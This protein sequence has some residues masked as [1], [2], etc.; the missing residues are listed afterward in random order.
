MA[1]R[2]GGRPAVNEIIIL[3][4]NMSEQTTTADL[5]RISD[6]DLGLWVDPAANLDEGALRRAREA[7]CPELAAP[8]QRLH[9]RLDA[10]GL[11]LV[12]PGVGGGIRVRGDFLGGRQGWRL[13]QAR[14]RREALARACDL[15]RLRAPEVIDATAGLGRDTALLAVLGARVTAIERQPAIAALLRDAL[16]RASADP[17]LGGSFRAV[18][19]CRAD[20]VDWLGRQPPGC[21]DVIYLDPMFQ[22]TGTAAVTK[23]MQ[24]LRRLLVDEPA[25]PALLAAARARARRRVVVKR[26]RHAPA[27]AGQAPDFSL[28]GRSTRFDVYVTSREQA[29]GRSA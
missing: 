21:A 23:E 7:G 20:A 19:V 9:L 18:S 3:H 1:P 5:N 26:H 13:R 24:L 27:L 4:S 14:H 8:P 22:E 16:A 12:L 10:G 2:R 28:P 6:K 15:G 29:G 25:T 17:D 11:A